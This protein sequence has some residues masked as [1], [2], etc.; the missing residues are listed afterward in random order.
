[1]SYPDF[2]KPFVIKADASLAAI[3][4]V[5]TQVVDGKERVISYGSKKLTDTQKKWS[6]YDREFW[7]LLCAIR[8]NAHYLRHSKFV[9]IT[10]HRPLLSW[11][12]V[13]SKKDPTGR[14]TRWCI[15]LDTYDFEL[16]YKAGKIHSDADAMSRLG[17]ENDETASDDEDTGFT[18]LGMESSDEYSAV[19]LNANDYDITALR[20]AQDDDGII[21]EAK[22]FIKHRK[23]IPSIIP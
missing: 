21:A 4:Y 15:E 9:A 17:N 2:S 19:R 11:R 3:G 10:D 1:M 22:K 18:L 5:L 6:T 7:A 20:K 13:D 8:A 14:R 23:R 16:I 12:K